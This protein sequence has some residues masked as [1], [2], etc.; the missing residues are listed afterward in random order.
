LAA[1]PPTYPS[2]NKSSENTVI[3]TVGRNLKYLTGN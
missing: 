1:S 2:Q 3:S